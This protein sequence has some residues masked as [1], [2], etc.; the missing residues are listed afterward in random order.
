MNA[1]RDLTPS[2]TRGVIIFLIIILTLICYISFAQ[3]QND[4][5]R[6]TQSEFREKGLFLV[7]GKRLVFLENDST[8]IMSNR[9]FRAYHNMAEYVRNGNLNALFE[10]YEGIIDEQQKQYESLKNKTDALY[11]ISSHK[12]NELRGDLENIDKKVDQVT[13]F[14]AEASEILKTVKP[15]NKS[16]IMYII[17][18]IAGVVVGFLIAK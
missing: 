7:K 6:I 8:Y 16:P 17:L 10:N 4:T 15:R 2:I 5:S 18:P 12:F 14:L 1:G 3:A 13:V 11:D 9:V